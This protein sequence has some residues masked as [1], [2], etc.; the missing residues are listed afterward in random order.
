VRDSIDRF[1]PSEALQGARSEE[2]GQRGFGALSGYRECRRGLR[3]A[4]SRLGHHPC[5]EGGLGGRERG[6]QS[7]RHLFGPPGLPRCLP[8]LP[9]GNQH[10]RA[11]R[12][13]QRLEPDRLR[14]PKPLGGPCQMRFGGFQIIG[15]PPDATYRPVV[16]RRE[17]VQLAVPIHSVGLRDE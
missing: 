12:H 13:Q 14:G 5:H 9:N 17:E 3:G 15:Q 7:A 2:G 11:L 1:H 10:V 16:Q 4:A 6:S 8:D